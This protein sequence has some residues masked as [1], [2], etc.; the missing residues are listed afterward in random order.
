MYY[1]HANIKLRHHNFAMTAHQ[2]KF[3][4]LVLQLATYTLVLG[5]RELEDPTWT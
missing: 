5:I 1:I 3:L 4:Q 2:L